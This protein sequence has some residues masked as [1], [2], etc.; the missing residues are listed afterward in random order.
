MAKKTDVITSEVSQSKE[1][2][3]KTVKYGKRASRRNYSKVRTEVDLPDLIEIQTASYAKFVDEGLRELFKD[4]SPITNESGTLEIN[5]GEHRFEEPKCDIVEAKQRDINFSRALKVMVRLTNADKDG[6][7]I[8][9]ELFMG[10]FPYMTPVGTFVVNGAERVIIS[11]IVRSSGVYFSKE[12]DKKLGVYRY[13]GQVIPTRGAWIEYETAS[14]DIWFAK[15]DRSKK[16][17]VS[18][19]LRSIGLSADEDITNLLGESDYLNAS[20]EK[21]TTNNSEDAAI[22]IY[23]KLRN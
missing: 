2:S 20:F 13:S 7:Q 19:F 10:D 21:D 16:I 4:I 8:E 6:E 5:F 17:P 22:E 14:K 12:L 11:Q 18:T 23:A 3:Y 15:L 1:G 9:K